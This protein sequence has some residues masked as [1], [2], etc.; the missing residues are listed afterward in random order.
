MDEMGEKV[1]TWKGGVMSFSADMLPGED[2]HTAY[3]RIM[4]TKVLD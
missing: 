3:K 4:K 2:V 1:G